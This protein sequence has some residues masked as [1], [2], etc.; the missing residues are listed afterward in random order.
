MLLLEFREAPIELKA[1]QL[2][3]ESSGLF[4]SGNRLLIPRTRPKLAN[5]TASRG[6]ACV[7]CLQAPSA[8][9]SF[10]CCSR[11][12]AS[13]GVRVLGVWAAARMV[14]KNNAAAQCIFRIFIARNLN[15]TEAVYPFLV[16]CGSWRAIPD[17]FF[18]FSPNHP[19]NG[20]PWRLRG[21]RCDLSR[22]RAESSPNLHTVREQ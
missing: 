2:V 21:G 8:S 22:I 3:I 11:A 9:A 6:L 15:A 4:I 5:A 16:S 1:R 18:R 13:D 12:T 20:V 14:E 17:G 7:I 10:P 19:A